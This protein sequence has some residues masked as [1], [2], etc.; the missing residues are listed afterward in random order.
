[1]FEG[2][3]LKYRLNSKHSLTSVEKNIHPHTFEISIYIEQIQTKELVAFS[4]ID[5]IIEHFLLSYQKQYL[6]S[7]PPFDRLEP[8]I[9]NM[10]NVFYEEL[11][12]ILCKEQFNLLQ[13]E[14]SENPLRL[15]LISD[16]LMFGSLNHTTNSKSQ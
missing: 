16:R 5:T 15:Y 14:I 9:E 13:L 8:T 11:K 1:M 12:V 6:N 7:I 2:Y 3:K 10:G 4:T